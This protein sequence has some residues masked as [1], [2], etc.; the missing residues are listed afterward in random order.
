MRENENESLIRL[1]QKDEQVIKYAVETKKPMLG[2]CRGIQS[3]VAFLGGNLYQDID[4]FNLNHPHEGIYHTVKKVNNMGV[5]K[6][7]PG[8]FTVNTYHHQ[9]ADRLPEGYHTLLMN[10]DVIEFIEHESLPILGAQWHPE[11]M[12]SEESKIILDYFLN[13][14]KNN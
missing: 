4:H 13:K 3:I 9:C 1:D 5:A 10:G 2:I 14:V 12:D 11:R 7:L 8:E 6:L